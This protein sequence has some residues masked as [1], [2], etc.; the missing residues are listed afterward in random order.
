MFAVMGTTPDGQTFF[1][2]L[3][4][5]GAFERAGDLSDAAWWEDHRALLA[6]LDGLDAEHLTALEARQA[7]P[8]EFAGPSLEPG[9]TPAEL[10]E[11][12]AF[13]AAGCWHRTPKSRRSA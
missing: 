9:V 1:L 5:A 11:A 13:R 6:W 12:M 7:R 8:V 3:T 10:D 2:R 4:A